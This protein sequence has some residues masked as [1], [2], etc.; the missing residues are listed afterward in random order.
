MSGVQIVSLKDT[1]LFKSL[2][3]GKNILSNKVVYP[4]TTRLRA[5][6]DHT[7]SDLELEYYGERSKYPGS[8]L[9]AEATY[10]SGTS[11]FQR[12]ISAC[13]EF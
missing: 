2:K 8:L 5:L 13:V 11:W 7:P 3:V 10:I 9:I 12:K 4:P 1:D 6:D